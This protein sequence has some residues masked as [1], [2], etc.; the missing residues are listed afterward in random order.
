MGSL[1]LPICAHSYSYLCQHP[2]L[3]LCR[4]TPMS[5]MIVY[6]VVCV[7]PWRRRWCRDGI[8]DPG[9][10][11]Q[12]P[13]LPTAISLC[14]AVAVLPGQWSCRCNAVDAGC[15]CIRQE[16]CFTCSSPPSSLFATKQIPQKST[17]VNKLPSP[18]SSPA[19]YFSMSSRQYWFT[20]LAHHVDCIVMNI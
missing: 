7:N 5:G 4:C 19:S 15:R 2:Y 17:T 6:R 1:P 14:S 12:I 20:R 16:Q 9:N 8:P 18:V 11:G 3:L 10:A 13:S